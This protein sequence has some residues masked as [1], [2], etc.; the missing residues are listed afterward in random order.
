MCSRPLNL[1]YIFLGWLLFA[2]LG[3]AY[4]ASLAL[5]HECGGLID[6]DAVDLQQNRD[7]L[8]SFCRRGG[9]H[10]RLRHGLDG[11]LRLRRLALDLRGEVQVHGLL[12]TVGRWQS[13]G[14]LLR[15]R[16][17]I[18][19]ALVTQGRRGGLAVLGEL[20]VGG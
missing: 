6:E 11:C 5:G 7:A 10:R 16:R 12:L 17:G 1:L 19:L 18:R 15:L 4:L 13:G 9:R 3:R 20:L 8:V 14:R 2:F